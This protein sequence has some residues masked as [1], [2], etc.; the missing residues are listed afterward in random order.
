MAAK[1]PA[2]GKKKPQNVAPDNGFSYAPLEFDPDLRMSKSDRALYNSQHPIWALGS[3]VT[4]VVPSPGWVDYHWGPM[5]PADPKEGKTLTFKQ[6]YTVKPG[7]TE[8][9]AEAARKQFVGEARSSAGRI[10]GS[11]ALLNLKTS[12]VPRGMAQSYIGF[13]SGAAA[14]TFILTEGLY[15][16][17]SPHT[18]TCLPW[19][20][21]P[22]WDSRTLSHMG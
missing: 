22:M 7:A 17:P 14:S 4:R 1:P 16:A 15:P 8:E 3:D 21:Y 11:R 9:D 18:P 5:P 19:A 6:L 13:Q 2:K 12:N 10:K 20:G